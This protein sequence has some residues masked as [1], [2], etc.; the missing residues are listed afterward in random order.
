MKQTKT[1]DVGT[2]TVTNN[3]SEGKI[4]TT[5]STLVNATNG[6]VTDGTP[7]VSRTE[8]VPKV[9][10]VGAKDKVVETL[11]EPEVEYGLKMLKRLWY[12]R[13]AY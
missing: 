12:T 11:I 4:V 1:K 3:G 2:N 13:S 5:T 7:V 9:V 6:T 8:M 10:K